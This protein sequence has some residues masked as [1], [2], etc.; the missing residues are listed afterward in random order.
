M[1]KARLKERGRQILL[2]LIVGFFLV[3]AQPAQAQWTVYDPANHATQLER[4]AQEAAR[5]MEKVNQYVEE[6][7][8]YETMIDK[9]VEQITSLGNILKTVDEELARHKSLTNAVASFGKTIRQI[10]QLQQDIRTMVTNRILAV[11]RV[12][13]RMR[14]GIFDPQQNMRDLEEY[15]R[16]SIGRASQQ[17][18]EYHELLL[19]QDAEFG[20]AVYNREVAFGRLAR[21]EEA[22]RALEAALTAETAKPAGEQQGV[23]SLL[24]QLADCKLYIATL[25]D[26]I[27]EYTRI[28]NDKMT[29]FGVRIDAHA[30]FGQA[31]VRETEAWREMTR[32][33][34]GT[35]RSL[36][37]LF[38]PDDPVEEVFD[39]PADEYEPFLIR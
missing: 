3:P 32:V 28:I 15:M 22:Q 6:I 31:V 12:W 36:D 7:K 4:M 2:G 17:R 13:D 19:E 8:K 35:L 5:W 11:Q 18:V 37:A 10:F 23:Q 39:Y 33:N 27:A 20:E 14:N 26:Q 9:Q 34:Q 1:S 21:A 24:Q 38:D 25:T 29:K 16:H 30:R